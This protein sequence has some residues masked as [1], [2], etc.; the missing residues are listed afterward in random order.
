M[1]GIEFGNFKMEKVG[2]R[3]NNL[4]LVAC[5][6][7]EYKEDGER[8]VVSQVSKDEAKQ[9]YEYLGKMLN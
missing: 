2:T 1:A 9:L 5:K 8:W 7:R 4:F 6:D 3:R